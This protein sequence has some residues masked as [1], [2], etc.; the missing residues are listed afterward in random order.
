MI[1]APGVPVRRRKARQTHDVVRWFEPRN[2]ARHGSHAA[3][4]LFPAPRFS[5]S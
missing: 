4:T 2:S 3:A 1:E 5:S